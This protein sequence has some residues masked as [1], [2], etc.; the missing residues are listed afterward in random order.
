[1]NRTLSLFRFCGVHHKGGA[2]ESALKFKFDLNA[3]LS[4]NTSSAVRTAATRSAQRWRPRYSDVIDVHSK[5]TNCQILV[6]QLFTRCHLPG[7]SCARESHPCTLTRILFGP[8]RCGEKRQC[9]VCVCVCR[10]LCSSEWHVNKNKRN[11]SKRK[12]SL[13]LS[14]R[15]GIEWV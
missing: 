10:A 12:P 9:E 3:N 2:T 15:D 6:W 8:L 5:Q 11:T 7:R 4:G 1:M 13:S 14:I